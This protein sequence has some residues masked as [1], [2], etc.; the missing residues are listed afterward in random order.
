MRVVARGQLAPQVA[1]HRVG[2]ERPVRGRPDRHEPRQHHGQHQGHAPASPQPPQPGGTPVRHEQRDRRQPRHHRRDRPFQQDARAHR[3]PEPGRLQLRQAR[4]VEISPAKQ[5][6]RHGR[7]PQQGRVGLG[8]VRL[9]HERHARRQHPRPQ[10]ARLPP[11]QPLADREAGQHG[12][13][14]AQQRRH[15]V[16]PD[17]VPRRQPNRARRRGERRLQPVDA[18]RLAVPRLLPV[19]DP[20]VVAGLDHLLGRLH[21]TALVA[22][23]GRQ[24]EQARQPQRQAKQRQQQ[25]RPGGLKHRC[26]RRA[27]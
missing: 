19:H 25:P 5:R 24:A 10:Q 13:Q 23:P 1:P 21:E 9:R 18:D 11:E 6:H 2:E 27:P 3:Q 17:R 20:H 12:N 26:H 14:P 7:R 8:D 22:V 15:A 4:R 16:R